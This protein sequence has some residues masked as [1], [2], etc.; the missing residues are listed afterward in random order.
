M[1]GPDTF[2]L[3]LTNIVLGALVGVCFLLVLLKV[4][5]EGVTRLKKRHSTNSELDHDMHE[6]FAAAHP[7]ATVRHA[8]SS[9]FVHRLLEAVCRIWRRSL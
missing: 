1:P 6:M 3:T 4:F 9:T 5:C 7:A 2:W 8:E